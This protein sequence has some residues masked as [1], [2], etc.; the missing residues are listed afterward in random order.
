MNVTACHVP[1]AI[2]LAQRSAACRHL[3]L[4][5]PAAAAADDFPAPPCPCRPPSLPPLLLTRLHARRFRGKQIAGTGKCPSPSSFRRFFHRSPNPLYA[6]SWDGV[7]PR[8][9]GPQSHPQTHSRTLGRPSPPPLWPDRPGRGQAQLRRGRGGT[10]TRRPQPAELPLPRPSVL[11][12]ANGVWDDLSDGKWVKK[13][14]RVRVAQVR[15]PRDLCR[16]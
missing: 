4:T 2:L 12:F 7:R 3:C 10:I 5:L 8:K 15:S 13:V 11:R 16:S 1:R 14:N 9:E 6:K